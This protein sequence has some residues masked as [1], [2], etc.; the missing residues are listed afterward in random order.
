MKEEYSI[1][2][3]ID[4]EVQGIIYISKRQFEKIKKAKQFETLKLSVEI[5]KAEV[6]K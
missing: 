4:K 1:P 6:S 2:F 5:Q 3:V